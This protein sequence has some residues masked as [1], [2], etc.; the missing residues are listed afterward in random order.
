MERRLQTLAGLIM[1]LAVLSACRPG[2][3]DA[4]QSSAAAVP[5][6]DAATPLAFS[7]TPPPVAPTRAAAFTATAAVVAPS[8]PTPLALATAT[9]TA[10]GTMMPEQ[11]AAPTAS[12]TPAPTFTPPPPPPP[13]PAEHFILSRP[14]PADSPQWTDKAYPYG[15]T[16][17]G[18]LQT[19]HGVEFNVPNGTAVLAAADGVVRFAGTDDVVIAGPQ[20]NFYGQA[21]VL[22]HSPATS[23]NTPLFTLYGHLSEVLVESGQRVNRGEVIGISGDSGVAYGPHLHF[24]VR[25]GTN[26]Y[27]TTRN[28]L[29]WLK[30]FDGLGVVAARIAWP[31]GRPV[32]E[33]PV[34]LRRIDGQAPYTAGT[35][36]ATGGAN[37]DDQRQENLVLDDVVPGYYELEVGS[38]AGAVRQTLWVFPDRTTFL[39]LALP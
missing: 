30:P 23:S 10:T 5:A 1:A 11:P 39:T 22:E 38:D 37:G 12:P 19:H 20:P 35:T 28:P 13:D 36:Y 34:V 27:S 18:T 6:G 31:D 16:R 26:N 15:S 33:A 3:Q 32:L 7:E 21:V 14:V 4:V 17:G 8:T 2:P 24:E 25:Q 29:L 9:V